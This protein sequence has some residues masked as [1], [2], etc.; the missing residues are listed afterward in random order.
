MLAA[1]TVE[2]ETL[3]KTAAAEKAVVEIEL[4][5]LRAN[6]ALALRMQAIAQSDLRELRQH[7]TEVQTV[8]ARQDELLRQ[9]AP[10]LQEAARHLQGLQATPQPVPVLVDGTTIASKTVKESTRKAK[11]TGK[12]T[13]KK[14]KRT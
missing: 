3:R 2:A 8:R 9:L 13:R 4:T 1:K 10:R 14:S 5:E 11:K 7:F 12:K 6:V